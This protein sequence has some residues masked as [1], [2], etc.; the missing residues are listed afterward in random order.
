MYVTVYVM[1]F[2]SNCRI[3]ATELNYRFTKNLKLMKFN[4]FCLYRE[5][6]NRPPWL[7]QYQTYISKW[8]INRKVFMSISVLA[9]ALKV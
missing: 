3:L 7:C 1:S 5:K 8:Y 6:R 4:E 2:N 9:T